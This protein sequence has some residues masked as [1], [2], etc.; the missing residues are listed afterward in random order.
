MAVLTPNSLSIEEKIGQIFF[1]GIP[2]KAVDETTVSLLAQVK[3]GGICLFGRN[4]S[5]AEQTRALTDAMRELSPVVPLLSIDQ[6]GGLVDRLR[7][8]LAPMPSASKIIDPAS[9][10]SQAT[11][12]ASALRLLGLNMDFA[13]VVDV[14]DERRAGPQNG[15]NSRTYGV[16]AHD[17][18]EI[19]G[20]FLSGLQAKGVIGC[21]K[22][23]PGLGASIVDSHEELPLVGVPP[24]ELAAVDLYPYRQLFT[25]G[26]VNAVM[27]AHAAYP[28]V[29]LQEADR[30]GTLLPSSLSSNFV[31]KLL[32]DKLGFDGLVLTDDLEMGA[33]VNNF[34]IGEA[35]VMAI[36]AGNDMACICAG[37]EAIGSAHEA[38]FRAV[39]SGRISAERLDASVARIL[40][41]KQLIVETV[42]FDHQAFS[43]LTDAIAQ[44]NENLA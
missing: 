38:V 27:V 21:L 11:I 1:I 28:E 40:K 24:D 3:P 43:S 30:D 15:L 7:R 13:P 33:I 41:T 32:R 25:A 5:D 9:A 17:V 20:A 14:I 42:P 29:P 34:G 26:L 23:F 44:L 8:I 22:H 31:T 10:Q 6:E 19:G 18:A 4:I 35:S 12:I 2:G 36:E 39:H 37:V 16:N